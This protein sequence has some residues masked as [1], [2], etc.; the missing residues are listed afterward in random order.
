MSWRSR[1]AGRGTDRGGIGAGFGRVQP[2]RNLSVGRRG[3]PQRSQSRD[4]A[5]HRKFGGR[6]GHGLPEPRDGAAAAHTCHDHRRTA[7]ADRNTGGEPDR[8]TGRRYRSG[9]IERHHGK[10]ESAGSSALQI[11]DDGFGESEGGGDAGWSRVS[12]TQARR[13]TRTATTRI[14][15]PGARGAGRTGAR[16]AMCAFAAAQS[17]RGSAND[18]HRSCAAK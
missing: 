8:D 1:L 17:C 13:A 3:Q 16:S 14:D 2:D 5:F 12:S 9:T 18:P 7:K 6:R 15:A 10:F 4:R 11:A